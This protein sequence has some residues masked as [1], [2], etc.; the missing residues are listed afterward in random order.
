MIFFET[1]TSKV[2][3]ILGRFTPERKRVLEGVAEEIRKYNMLPIIFDFDRP[4][5]RDFTETI[6]TLAGISLF[7]I[8]DI[9]NPHSAPLELQ[10]VSP[11]YQ[12]PIV[13]IIQEGEKPFSMFR[14]LTAKY[15]W[16]L[17]LKQYSSLETLLSDFKV[18]VI[19]RALKK[20]QE[21][22]V[23]KQRLVNSE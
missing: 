13:P 9:S 3:L 14:D 18:T 5:S 1:I 12:I 2:V 20:H 21:L 15:D 11:D 22:Q 4:A 8:A 23:K 7:I 16:V 6:K 19:D 10:A 17:D